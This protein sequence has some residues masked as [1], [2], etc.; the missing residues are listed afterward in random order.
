MKKILSRP[1]FTGT[2]DQTERTGFL[3]FRQMQSLGL[4]SLEDFDFIE[5]PD[6]RLG[7]M[8]QSF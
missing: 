7:M 3:L 6:F 4:G 1:E 2:R 8:A 5:P